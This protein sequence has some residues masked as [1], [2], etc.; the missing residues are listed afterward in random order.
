MSQHNFNNQ[1]KVF[2]LVSFTI[3][4]KPRS[5][6]ESLIF[7]QILKCYNG[8]LESS[9]HV[10]RLYKLPSK[11]DLQG[12]AKYRLPS[13]KQQIIIS[14]YKYVLCDTLHI[15]MLKSYLLFL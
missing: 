7:V 15:F 5:L 14:Y 10:F 2:S 4:S 8:F 3:L 6:T 12:S 1:F 11:L 9:R 13:I